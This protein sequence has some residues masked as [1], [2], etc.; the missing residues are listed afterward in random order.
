LLVLKLEGNENKEREGL[1]K[2][3]ELGR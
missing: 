1:E 3:K 2:N